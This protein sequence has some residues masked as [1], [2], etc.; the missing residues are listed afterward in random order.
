[1]FPNAGKPLQAPAKEST[2]LYQSFNGGAG[3]VAGT[4]EGRWS[5]S[6]LAVVKLRD[7][8]ACTESLGKG[9][10]TPE[11]ELSF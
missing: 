7:E 2:H 4:S 10:P 9:G 6:T 11:H 5:A 3:A 1:M 8:F